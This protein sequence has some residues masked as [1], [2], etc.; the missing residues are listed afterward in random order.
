M[1]GAR[2][3]VP[4]FSIQDSRTHR[5]A[6]QGLEPGVFSWQRY[7]TGSEFTTRA[8]RPQRLTYEASGQIGLRVFA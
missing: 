3:S 5:G 6:C 2:S 4:G 8:G 7:S 1:P